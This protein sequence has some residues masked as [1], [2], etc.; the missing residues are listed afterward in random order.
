MNRVAILVFSLFT[1]SLVFLSLNP[2]FCQTSKYLEQGISQYRQENYEE[3]IEI[4][5]KAREEDP[6]SSIAAFFLGLAYKQVIDY[7]RAITHLKDAITL[8]PRIKDAVVELV[9]ILVQQGSLQEAKWWIVLAEREKIN[10]ANIAFLKGLVLQ[11]EGKNLEAIESFKK[12]K[13]LDKSI[14]QSS[15]LQIALCYL[16]ESRLKEAKQRFQAA[17]LYDPLSDLAAFA[18]QYQD[19]VEKRIFLER[20]LRFTISL[21]GQYDTNMVLK[22]T[23][24]AVATGITDEKSPALAANMRMDYVPSLRDPWLFNASYSFSS[25]QYQKHPSTHNTIGNSLFVAPGYRFGRFALNLAATYSY[26]LVRNPDYEKYMDYLNVGPLFRMLLK[27]NQILELFAGYA[28]KNYFM[29]PLIPEED[30]DSGGLDS[31]ISWFWLFKEGGFLNLRYEFINEDAEGTNWQN[32]GNKFTLNTAFPLNKRLKLQLSES[33]FLQRYENTHTV[34]NIGREDDTFTGSA[35]LIWEY[36]R[37][38][39]FVAQVSRIKSNSNLPI[40][41]YDRDIYALGIEVKL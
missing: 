29:P 2:A 5:K 17:V 3:A 8:T 15:D 38:L 7:P 16:K 26:Y 6:T 20:P 28:D 13:S 14:V 31:S 37:N 30:K 4:L 32:K 36:S 9:D 41:K 1:L 25:N 40:Y 10:P 22:P 19:M 24:E 12:A 34:F 27:E 11:K 18:R 33:V 21:F 35:G 39:S 23:E